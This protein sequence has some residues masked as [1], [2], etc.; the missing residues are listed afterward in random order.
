MFLKLLKHELRA[1]GR[2]L[3]PLFGGLILMALLAR[4][5]IWLLSTSQ[6]SVTGVLSGS[7][8]VLFILG[9]FGVVIVTAVLMMV[10]FARS[11]HGDEG[12]LTNTLPVSEHAI[13]LSRVLISFFAIAAACGVVYLGYRICTY[14]V[15]SFSDLVNSL[16]ELF[17]QAEVDVRATLWK[18]LASGALSLLTLILQIFAAI[19]IGHSFNTGKTG[20]S[21]TS[22]RSPFPTSY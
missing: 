12:Y 6:N 10:R 20:K 17:L 16:Q 3:L 2:A 19:S 11:V 4:G 7:L 5:S 1:S 18:A 14:R 8:I 15:K 22:A 13:L 21:T 9:C